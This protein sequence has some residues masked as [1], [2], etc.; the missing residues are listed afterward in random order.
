MISE[1]EGTITDVVSENKKTVTIK[2]E[3]LEGEI[4]EYQVP[5][6]STLIVSKGQL[7]GKGTQFNEGHIDLNVRRFFANRLSVHSQI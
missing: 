1:V 7:I 3:T 2:I 5:S 6:E 4:K